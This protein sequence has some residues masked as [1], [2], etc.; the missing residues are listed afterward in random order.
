MRRLRNIAFFTV[1]LTDGVEHAGSNVW[2][3]GI[4]LQQDPGLPE[5]PHLLQ[6]ALQPLQLHHSHAAHHLLLDVLLGWW[7]RGWEQ[8]RY[9]R[10]DNVA[11]G[12]VLKDRG[13]RLASPKI[14]DYYVPIFLTMTT[15]V[16]SKAYLYG[17][18]KRSFNLLIRP[19]WLV[20]LQNAI[21]H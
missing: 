16:N 8:A 14:I 5:L 21:S 19:H 12:W 3:G 17:P 9:D 13:L 1:C 7:W 18:F 2:P 4:L 10:Q 15:L 11:E 20:L 6:Q